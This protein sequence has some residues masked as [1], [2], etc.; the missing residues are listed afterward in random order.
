[1]GLSYSFYAQDS[2]KTK[3]VKEP[4]HFFANTVFVDYYSKPS[5]DLIKLGSNSTD[6]SRI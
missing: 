3:K 5:T 4:K 2:T 6:T 1:M